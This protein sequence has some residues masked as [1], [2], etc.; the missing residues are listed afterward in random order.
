MVYKA[1][2]DTN[3]PLPSFTEEQLAQDWPQA[4]GELLGMAYHLR[5]T[6][7]L[8]GIAD[9]IYMAIQLADKAYKDRKNVPGNG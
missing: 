5:R 3:V 2:P 9:H 1:S 4:S 6:T 8:K 7:G